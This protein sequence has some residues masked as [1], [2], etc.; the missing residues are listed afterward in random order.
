MTETLLIPPLIDEVIQRFDQSHAPFTVHNVDQALSKARRELQ[1]PTETENFG[2]WT[3]ILAFALVGNR[4]DTSPWGTYFSPLASGTD[5]DGKLFYSPDIAD[6][7]AD[8]IQHWTERVERITHPVLRARYA[9]L[10]W[11]MTPVITGARL[12]RSPNGATRHRCVPI[13]GDMF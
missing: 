4:T 13:L 10:V 7:N 5:E 2:A 9:D 11:E 6:A 1:N 3:E 12:P 8:V